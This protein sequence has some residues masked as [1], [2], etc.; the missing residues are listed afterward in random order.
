MM[1]TVEDDVFVDLVTDQIDAGL[2]GNRADAA[3]DV[4]RKYG[5]RRISG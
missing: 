2:G 1:C 5:A 4:E 3:H